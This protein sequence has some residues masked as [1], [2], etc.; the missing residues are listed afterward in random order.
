[1]DGACVHQHESTWPLRFV[2]IRD[3]DDEEKSV[4]KL[5]NWPTRLPATG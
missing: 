4:G 3:V 2:R 1:M 5:T